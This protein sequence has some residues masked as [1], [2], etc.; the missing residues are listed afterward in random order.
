M[1]KISSIVRGNPRVSS[2]DMQQVAP[3]RA[4]APSF[5]RPVAESTGFTERPSTAQKAVAIHNQMIESKKA[6]AGD[7]TVQAM[8]D[9]F[10]MSRV[11]RPE[12]QAAVGA[13]APKLPA[14]GVSAKEDAGEDTISV[15]GPS[16]ELLEAKYTPRG[17]YI[18]VRA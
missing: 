9:Q 2:V 13:I 6:L 15:S 12:E 8:A 17:S 14:E 5:G 18:D 16:E 11:R 7:R 4:G 1:E 10:F 3:A